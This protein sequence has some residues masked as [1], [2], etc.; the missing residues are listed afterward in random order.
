MDCVAD[1]EFGIAVLS[2]LENPDYRLVKTSLLP[3][4]GT[5]HILLANCRINFYLPIALRLFR[6]LSTD[7][8]GG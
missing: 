4:G 6:H 1:G 7:S 3:I 2:G 8:M 5:F